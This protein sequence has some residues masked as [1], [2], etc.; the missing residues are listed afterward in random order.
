MII[1]SEMAEFIDQLQQWH[2]NKISQLQ[3]ILLYSDKN[4]LL[5]D[6]TIPADTE[7]AKG[8]RIGVGIALGLLSKLPFSLVKELEGDDA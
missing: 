3:S 6:A 8:I 7:M 5:G 2:H 1:D 4:I